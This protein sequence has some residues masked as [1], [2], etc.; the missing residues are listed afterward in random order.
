MLRE[1]QALSSITEK[2]SAYETM[3]EQLK[4]MTGAD[5][6]EEVRTCSAITLSLLSFFLFS[7]SL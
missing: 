3:F 2:I 4:K 6:L 7:V 1:Q 5:R